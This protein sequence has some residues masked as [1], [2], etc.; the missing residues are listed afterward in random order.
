MAARRKQWPQTRLSIPLRRDSSSIFPTLLYF[1][2]SAYLL[3]LQ[4]RQVSYF[5]LFF[6][7]LLA[8]SEQVR[9]KRVTCF[10]PWSVAGCL[11]RFLC[12]PRATLAGAMAFDLAGDYQ[13]MEELGCEC[14][15]PILL[16]ADRRLIDI[17]H[18]TG[19]S[20]GTVYKAIERSTGEIVAVKH[21][22]RHYL[23]HHSCSSH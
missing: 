23:I 9:L 8:S 7:F 2:L 18:H 19:G 6:F 14:R 12:I 13:M 20:F 21:V 22:C 11:F 3:L 16:L 10:P 15:H 1:I 5:F 4:T 17:D